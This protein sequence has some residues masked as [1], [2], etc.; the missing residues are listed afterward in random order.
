MFKS[1]IEQL[2][3][4][5]F[6]FF[7]KKDGYSPLIP[8]LTSICILG[9]FA[10][11]VGCVYLLIDLFYRNALSLP[12]GAR[13]K[14]ALIFFLF[15]ILNYI[16]LFSF[17]KIEKKGDH[18]DHIFKMDSVKYQKTLRIVLII[19]LTFFAITAI[20]IGRRFIDEQI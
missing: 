1:V 2:Y 12:H 5:I 17:L 4:T 16:F 10:L 3:R 13:F 14:V 19:I 7:V 9:L 18:E 8:F 15:S 11:M 6:N 20:Y